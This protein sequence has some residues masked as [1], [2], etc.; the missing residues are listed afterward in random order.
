[1]ADRY[2]KRTPN[3]GEIVFEVKNWKVHHAMHADRWSIKGIDL[4]VRRGEIVGIAGLMGAGRTELAMSIFGR[5]YGQGISG[6]VFMKGREVDTSTVEKAVKHGIAYV[7]EDR[8]GY[9]LVLDETINWNTTLGQPGCRQSSQHAWSTA[10]AN[11]SV[12]EEYR[13]KLNIRSSDVFQRVVNCR[14]ATSRR[15]C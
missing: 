3:I 7:T 10:G 9:G 8:K 4:H 13:K 15:W 6:Q 11:T 12:A 1:M 14:A 2:P 5:S